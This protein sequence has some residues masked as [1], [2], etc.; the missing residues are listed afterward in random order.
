MC[1]ES[2]I[3]INSICPVV[4]KK[5]LKRGANFRIRAASHI[6]RGEKRTVR[7]HDEYRH[8]AIPIIGNLTNGRFAERIAD[9]PTLTLCLDGGQTP[10]SNQR[11]W[12]LRVHDRSKDYSHH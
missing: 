4:S 7:L 11:G 12:R 1:D 9:L 8:V 2:F 3:H 5:A 10:G 6:S